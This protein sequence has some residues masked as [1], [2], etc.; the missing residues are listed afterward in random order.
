[1]DLDRFSSPLYGEA[2]SIFLNSVINSSI[3]YDITIVSWFSMTF[4]SEIFNISLKMVLIEKT[5]KLRYPS[6]DFLYSVLY[7]VSKNP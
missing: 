1:M 5:R 2:P 7:K 3:S 4:N 6:C